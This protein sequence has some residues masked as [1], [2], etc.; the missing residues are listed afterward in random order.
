MKGFSHLSEKGEVTMV[1]ITD[2][3]ISQRYAHAQGSISMAPETIIKIQEGTMHKGSVLMTAKIAGIM[4]AKNTQTAIPLCH[5]IL[6]ESIDLQFELKVDHIIINSY[7]K[8]VA[9]TGAEMEALHAVSVALLTVYDMCKAVDK[10]MKIKEIFLCEK[11][12]R[13]V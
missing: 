8:C 9:K 3:E 10:S 12:K 1:E 5:Q 11:S 2:K 4:A 13:S 7:I 6:L